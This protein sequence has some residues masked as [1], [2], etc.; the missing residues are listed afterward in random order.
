[1]SNFWTPQNLATYNSRQAE[2]AAAAEQAA[3]AAAAEQAQ[4]H[5]SDLVHNVGPAAIA[6][7]RKYTDGYVRA[8]YD[9]VQRDFLVAFPSATRND[10]RETVD[11]LIQSGHIMVARGEEKTM[12]A[13]SVYLYAA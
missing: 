4:Q 11:A 13:R 10:F 6:M 3:Q 2:H 9:Q 7:I 1:M 12:G 5:R 8:D